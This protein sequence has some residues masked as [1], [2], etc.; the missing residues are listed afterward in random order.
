M[1]DT[2]IHRGELSLFKMF[3]RNKDKKDKYITS[4][5]ILC[6]VS[7]QGIFQL[8]PSSWQVVIAQI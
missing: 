6:C 3:S 5:F 2:T 1:S 7:S 4:E 8:H